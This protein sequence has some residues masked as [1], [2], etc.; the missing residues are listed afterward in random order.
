MKEHIQHCKTSNSFGY[1]N[2]EVNQIGMES[3]RQKR[4]RAAETVGIDNN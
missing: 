2:E 1:N 3:E 4:N